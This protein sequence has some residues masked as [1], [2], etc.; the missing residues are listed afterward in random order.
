MVR[1]PSRP[2][3]ESV[4][5]S[6]TET[7]E[8]CGGA[9]VE[10]DSVRRTLCEEVASR[11]RG[12]EVGRPVAPPAGYVQT[13]G[14]PAPVMADEYGMDYGFMNELQMSHAG[15]AEHVQPSAVPQGHMMYG[16]DPA[17]EEMMFLAHPGP[18]KGGQL[19]AAASTPGSPPETPPGSSPQAGL[20]PFTVVRVA[21]ESRGAGAAAGR[22]HGAPLR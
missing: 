17:L 21:A 22:L 6:V 15:F 19:H 1:E 16:A 2:V 7:V 4:T 3:T 8:W 11:W 5:A 10:G 14:A 9:G 12:G 13:S 20:T 18:A